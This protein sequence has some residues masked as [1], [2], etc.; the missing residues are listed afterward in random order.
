MDAPAPAILPGGTAP[1]IAYVPAGPVPP[2]ATSATTPPPPS[3]APSSRAESTFRSHATALLESGETAMTQDDFVR[4]IAPANED[5]HKIARESYAV[6]FS[7]ADRAHRGLISFQDWLFF[8]TI[9]QKPDAEYEIA[10]R[11]FDTDGNGVVDYAE[12]I[13]YYNKNKSDDSVPFDWNCDW[14]TLYLGDKKKRHSMTYQQ[15]AQMLRGLQGERVRQA[16]HFY[17]KSHTGYIDPEQFQRIIE[18]TSKHK[19][20]DRLLSS[21][22]TLCNISTSSKISYASVRAFVNVI[23]ETDMVDVIVRRACEKS[24]DGKITRLDF[25]NEAARSTMFSLFTPMEID[26]LFHFASLDNSSGRLSHEDFRKVLDPSWRDPVIVYHQAQAE[27]V[28]AAK[29]ALQHPG[30]FLSEVFESVYHFMLGSVAGAFGATIVY[31]IDLVKTRMQNQRSQVPGQLLY[32]NSI[33]CFRKVVHNEGFRG[34]YS[35]LGPQL[36]G[37]APEKAIKLTVNDFA[38]GK[39]TD[40][41]G[42]ISLMSEIIAGGSA[43]ACQVVFT[44][45]LEIVKIRLQIQGEV[46]RSIEGATKRSAVWIVRNLG[47]LGLYKGATAC[48]MRDVPF[49]AIYFPTYAHLKKDYFG[50]GPNKSLGIGQLLIAGAVAG[51]P[52]AYLTTPCDVIKTRLQAE[53][54]AGQ[55]HYKNIAHCATTIFREEG[56]KAF[57][58]GGPAR[59]FR[60]SPQFGCTLAAY[61]M[62]Q[63]MLPYHATIGK[64][65]AGHSVPSSEPKALP[66]DMRNVEYLRSRNAL[67]ILLDIDENFGKPKVTQLRDSWKLVPG[68]SSK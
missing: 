4:A 65:E 45:P 38:R 35:G 19:L 48:L 32:K 26:V 28:D 55:T 39:L 29:H 57:F 49:S 61:E 9:L 41:F 25:T 43:G 37:V 23:R 21:L 36:V 11:L 59:I 50:E 12:F 5:Y 60:S 31:P 22:Q 62:L 53:A 7:V 18:Q 54:R 33:D 51:M 56:F 44:N 46:A 6:L 10:F 15:F 1:A 27:K 67:K 30:H 52:A 66:A 47:L 3:A 14:V 68:F 42:N 58:K 20:S 64:S 16:F 8:E 34:L 2:S 63:T 40:E 24:K 13:D 17:D